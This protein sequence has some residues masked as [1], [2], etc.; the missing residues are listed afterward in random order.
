MSLEA[1]LTAPAV[2]PVVVDRCARLV[3]DQVQGT[4]GLS[5]L[6]I[7]GAYKL[8]CAIKPGMIRDVVDR[9]LPDFARALEPTHER[10]IR[11][12]GPEGVGERFCRLVR[13]DPDAAAEALLS[14][15]DRKI[16]AAR[17]AIRAAYGRLRGSAHPHVAA[18]AP[19]LAVVVAEQLPR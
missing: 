8:V 10:A 3:D 9:L 16:A 15:T 13:Q 18:A 12:A 6:A 2:R 4:S 14:V 5:G 17:P 7:K 19:G 1:I 11:E